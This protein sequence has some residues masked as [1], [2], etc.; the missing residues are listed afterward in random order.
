MKTL[1]TLSTV[2]GLLVM[3]SGAAAATY[4]KALSNG[5]TLKVGELL[6]NPDGYVGKTVKVEGTITDVCE[7]KGCWMVIAGDNELESIKFK[8]KDGVI[9]IPQ[10]AKGRKAVA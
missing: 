9:V 1:R 3:A 6:A 8:V 7:M 5:A 2:I 4:G 10:E